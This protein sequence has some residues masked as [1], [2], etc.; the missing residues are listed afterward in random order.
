MN[1]FMFFLAVALLGIKKKK[2]STSKTFSV[3]RDL[4]LFFLLIIHV[5]NL[6]PIFKIDSHHAVPQRNITNNWVTAVLYL[7][8]KYRKRTV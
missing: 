6:P 5:L 8:H 1:M 7:S 2:N 3:N 4:F